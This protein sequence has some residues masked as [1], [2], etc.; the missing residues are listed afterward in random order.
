MNTC[1]NTEKNNKLLIFIA[2][3]H[4]SSS[5]VKGDFKVFIL[6]TQYCKS[7]KKSCLQGIETRIKSQVLGCWIYTTEALLRISDPINNVTKLTFK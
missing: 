6:Q 4:E 3:G 7:E 1:F 5:G 2:F